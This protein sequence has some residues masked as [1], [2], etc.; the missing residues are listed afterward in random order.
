M[1]SEADSGRAIEIEPSH[2]YSTVQW[3]SENE[4]FASLQIVF[5]VHFFCVTKKEREITLTVKTKSDNAG[6]RTE[7]KIID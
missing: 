4:D 1:I 3:I 7:M 6:Q 5:P 2:P